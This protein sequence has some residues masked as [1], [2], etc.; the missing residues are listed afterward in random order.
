MKKKSLYISDL[1]GTLL[2]RH[3][4]ISEYTRK[5][6]NTFIASGGCFS[7]ATARTAVSSTQILSGLSLNL[8]VVLMNGAVIY[9]I[10]NGKYIKT[11]VIP[12]AAVFAIVEVLKKQKITGFMYSFFDNRLQIYYESLDIAAVK[13]YHDE[14]IIKYAKPFVQVASFSDKIRGNK[15]IYFA[16][17]GDKERLTNLM[18][19]L[20]KLQGIDMVLSNDVYT[21]TLWY[22]EV[23]SKNAS[24]YNAVNYIREHCG[25]GRII[26]FGDNFNDIPLARVCDEFYAVSNAVYEL[27][28]K[29]TGII[30]D[31]NSDGVAR[32]IVARRKF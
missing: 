22:L 14:R 5:T 17:M 10:L 1:D 2:N 7:V 18:Q 30:A 25:F 26:G 15:V 6:L 28:E 29:S 23:Y 20:K 21:K 32:F 24:K 27:K 9:D 12:E 8:P 13:D 16:F 19:H 11:E 31:N 4:R 3:K